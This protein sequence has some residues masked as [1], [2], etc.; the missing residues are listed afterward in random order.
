MEVDVATSVTPFVKND[1]ETYL[2]PKG[3][4]KGVE[5]TN[6]SLLESILDGHGSCG[7]VTWYT[8]S[9]K[10][11]TRTFELKKGDVMDPCLE[12]LGSRYVGTWVRAD[13]SVPE[14]RL[15]TRGHR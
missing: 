7:L 8:T 2:F 3:V 1:I 4:F 6:R 5:N 12:D 13:A 14:L 11:R 10:V 15:C 9:T